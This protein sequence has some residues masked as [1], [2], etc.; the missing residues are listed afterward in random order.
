[1]F[2]ATSDSQSSTLSSGGTRPPS[3]PGIVAIGVGVTVGVSVIVG[4][5]VM[6]GVCV[7]V[8]VAVTVGVALPVGVTV[9]VTVGVPVRVRVMVGVSVIVGV[10]VN[11]WQ[12]VAPTHAAFITTEQPSMVLQATPAPV[13]RPGH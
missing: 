9:G 10:G 11:V 8:G 12:D 13:H 4:V 2:F 3:S 6:V 5:G 7:I 1:M